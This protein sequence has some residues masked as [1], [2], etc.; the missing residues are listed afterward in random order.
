MYQLKVIYDTCVGFVMFVLG[1]IGL[2]FLEAAAGPALIRT[3]AG[4]RFGIPI[5]LGWFGW[6]DWRLAPHSAT[7][8]LVTFLL[9]IVFHLFAAIAFYCALRVPGSQWIFFYFLW[10]G[11]PVCGYLLLLVMILLIFDKAFFTGQV[12]ALISKVV[13]L[14]M[15]E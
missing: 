9:K 13:A 14:D 1:L 5:M 8:W 11:V 6:F 2:F 15:I 3:I 10:V 7:G 4:R 12:G